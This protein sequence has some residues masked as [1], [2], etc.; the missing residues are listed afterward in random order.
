L[1]Y[2]SFW[3]RESRISARRDLRVPAKAI[4]AGQLGI[5]FRELEARRKKLRVLI[6][7]ANENHYQYG[8]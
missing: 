3:P 8:T 6:D 4:G 5:S 1:A 7:T 2:F